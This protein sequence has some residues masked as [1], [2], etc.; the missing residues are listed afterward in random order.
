MT[1]SKARVVASVMISTVLLLAGA[2]RSQPPAPSA[3]GCCCVAKGR[4]YTCAEK[5]QGDC[6]AEQPA[7][8]T[9]PRTED[10]KKAWDDWMKASEAAE[11]KP[12]RGGWI[13]GPCEK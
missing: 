10:W 3:P 6:L 5:T 7:I 1:P 9:F 13:A 12:M 4:S 8:P 11:A 2:A